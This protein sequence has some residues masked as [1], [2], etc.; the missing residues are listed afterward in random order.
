MEETMDKKKMSELISAADDVTLKKIADSHAMIS[1]D[2][3]EEL[4]AG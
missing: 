1:D 3:K 4:Y 2:K